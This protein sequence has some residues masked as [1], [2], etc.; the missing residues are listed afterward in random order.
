MSHILVCGGGGAIKSLEKKGDLVT[1]G[2][3]GILWG[4]KDHTDIYGD[5]YTPDTYFGAH[6]GVN[7]DTM[8]HHGIPLSP[9]LKAY[10]DILLPP[11]VRA[12]DDE[13]GKLIATVL[14]LKDCYQKAIY[15]MC[16]EGALS[17]SSGANRRGVRRADN[18]KRGEIVQWPLMEWS[19]TPTPAE[20]RMA[21]ITDL[22]EVKAAPDWLHLPSYSKT[23]R[24]L[25]NLKRGVTEESQPQGDEG[26]GDEVKSIF[27][28][29]DMGGYTAAQLA[30]EAV[31]RLIY[32]VLYEVLQ[33]AT[34]PVQ[35]GLSTL[36]RATKA[37]RLSFLQQACTEFGDYIFKM[38]ELILELQSDEE[39]DEAAKSLRAEFLNLKLARRDGL[40]LAEE[41]EAALAAVEGF[42]ERL[43]DLLE[44]RAARKSTGRP[45]LNQTNRDR[46][47]AHLPALQGLCADMAQLLELSGDGSSQKKPDET[48][49]APPLDAELAE[50]ELRFYETEFEAVAAE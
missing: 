40:T 36:T 28:I 20:P 25:T 48:K 44:D 2:D 5:W 31:D 3:Y 15:E 29:S 32:S 11:T 7:L 6:K 19:Y 30:R 9:E 38:A 49:S 12:E 37:E 50:L 16:E 26:Q 39:P 22:D 10:A 1:V 43:D 47:E 41:S 21:G 14:N 18:L 33:P 45:I 34:E 13:H 35:I 24:V 4:D 8:L 27:R 46:I 42:K 17:W 23:V